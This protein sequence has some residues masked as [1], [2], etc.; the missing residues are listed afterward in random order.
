M[1]CCWIFQRRK[2]EFS[3]SIVAMRHFRQVRT[4]HN[5][6]VYRCIALEKSVF[7]P[8]AGAAAAAAVRKKNRVKWNGKMRTN[9]NI[10]SP[11][12]NH[13]R[14]KT[15]FVAH[16]QSNWNWVDSVVRSHMYFCLMYPMWWWSMYVLTGTVVISNRFRT[17][18]S[19]YL[20]KVMFTLHPIAHTDTQTHTT[21][22]LLADFYKYLQL[23]SFV[24]F[25]SCSVFCCF[26]V[27]RFGNISN[28]IPPIF[29]ITLFRYSLNSLIHLTAS[30]QWEIV[31]DSLSHDFD[32]R[33]RVGSGSEWQIKGKRNGKTVCNWYVL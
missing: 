18:V 19:Y 12:K 2:K 28:G 31:L 15:Y 21:L 4:A 29:P 32:C 33:V 6:I 9:N 5:T 27:V 7:I 8:A 11:T 20:A 1:R 26:V 13:Q 10:N 22:K 17:A 23:I 25:W 16:T 24:C 14:I 30:S 3:H